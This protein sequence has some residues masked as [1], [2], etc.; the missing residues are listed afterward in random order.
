MNVTAELGE[1][2]RILSD[3]LSAMDLGAGADLRAI[4]TDTAAALVQTRDEVEATLRTYVKDVRVYAIEVSSKLAAAKTWFDAFSDIGDFVQNLMGDLA[5]S[6]PSVD[7]P[8]PPYLTI[9]EIYP[10]IV[11]DVTGVIDAVTLAASEGADAVARAADQTRLEFVTAAAR[12]PSMFDLPG[13]ISVFQ[14]Y[15]PPPRSTDSGDGGTQDNVAAADAYAVS[16]NAGAETRWSVFSTQVDSAA[17]ALDAERALLNT[18][19]A[20]ATGDLEDGFADFESDAS[21]ALENADPAGTVATFAADSAAR[22]DAAAANASGAAEWLGVASPDFDALRVARA[23]ASTAA[24]GLVGADLAYRFARSFQHIARHFKGSKHGRLPPVDLTIAAAA[25]AAGSPRNGKSAFMTA[26]AA[27]GHPVCLATVRVSA[28][29]L[30]V[31]LITQA[32][33]PF[34]DAYRNGCVVGCDGT[35]VT[36]NIH[37][38]SHNFAAAAATRAAESGKAQVERERHVA[39]AREAPKS[40][41]ELARARADVATATA[42]M[43]RAGQEVA[44]ARRCVDFRATRLFFTANDTDTNNTARANA[45]LAL[46]FLEHVDDAEVNMCLGDLTSLNGSENGFGGFANAFALDETSLFDCAVLRPCVSANCAGPRFE[47]LA[48]LARA[49]GTFC[50]LFVE[51]ERLRIQPLL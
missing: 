10:Q 26:A 24:D 36:Q 43:R 27:I 3:G 35:F 19:R 22:L 17:G 25:A 50:F 47:T 12:I 48:P 18:T 15:R 13:G 4:A 49:T 34:H 8:V 2:A 14:D 39:C 42:N 16:A 41:A 38:F 28:A 46:A 20:N 21:D 30:V 7:A 32:Y 44:R 1:L 29:V 31:T 6:L 9:A 51:P 11:P 23:A 33:L 45:S 5:T 40:A 37:S